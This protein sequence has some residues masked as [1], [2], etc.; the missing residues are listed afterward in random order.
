MNSDT[1]SGSGSSEKDQ[2]WEKKKMDRN[3]I[4]ANAYEKE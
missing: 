4:V 2:V 3:A 1:L